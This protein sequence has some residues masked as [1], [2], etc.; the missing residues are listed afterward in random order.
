MYLENGHIR[1]EEIIFQIAGAIA[2]TE[3]SVINDT[4]EMKLCL[5]AGDQTSW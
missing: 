3:V 2:S 5:L 1:H 4:V